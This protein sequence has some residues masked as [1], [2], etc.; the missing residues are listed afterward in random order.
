MTVCTQCSRHSSDTVSSLVVLLENSDSIQE[1][2]IFLHSFARVSNT[3]IKGAPAGMGESARSGNG[4]PAAMCCLNCIVNDEIFFL[5]LQYHQ[6]ACSSIPASS[7]IQCVALRAC[8]RLTLTFWVSRRAQEFWRRRRSSWQ[9]SSTQ[10][11][12]YRVTTVLPTLPYFGHSGKRQKVKCC[13]RVRS[14]RNCGKSHTIGQHVRQAQ[15]S[16]TSDTWDQAKSDRQGQS[17]IGIAA[18][19]F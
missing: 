17:D 5:S 7:P 19:N 11:A 12:V 6:G 3:T 4:Y 16:L 1:F 15:E 9:A 18:P 14:G 13:R 2:L 10:T 8:V